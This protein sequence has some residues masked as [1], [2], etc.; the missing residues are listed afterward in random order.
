MKKTDKAYRKGI[1]WLLLRSLLI[2]PLII[3]VLGVFGLGWWWALVPALLLNSLYWYRYNQKYQITN[4]AAE[5]TALIISLIFYY[6]GISILLMAYHYNY[7]A[8]PNSFFGLLTFPYNLSSLI[9]G[10][11]LLY[12]RF[13]WFIIGTFWS[14]SL[15][16]VCYQIMTK[17]L[18]K[19]SE[20]RL[21]GLGILVVISCFPFYQ[22][23]SKSLQY[24]GTEGTSSELNLKPYRPFTRHADLARLKSPT[25]FQITTH[26]PRLDGAT[27]AYPIY[28]AVAQTLY[29]GLTAKPASKLIRVGTTPQAF[30]RLI[31]KQ[32]DVIFMAQPSA[33]QYQAAKRAHVHLKLTKIGSEAFVFFVNRRNP[34]NSLSIKQIRSIYQRKILFWSSVGGRFRTIQPFQRAK[35]SGSQTAMEKLIMGNH[36]MAKPLRYQSVDEMGEIVDDVASYNNHSNAIGYSFRFYMT[37]M[38]RNPKIKL[39]KINHI[40][41]TAANIRNGRYPLIAGIYAISRTGEPKNSQRLICWLKSR[42]GQKLIDQTGYVSL[43]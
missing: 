15:G 39:L 37:Q 14:G 25:A 6:G 30:H 5:I 33:S 2:S 41:P 21:I 19:F 10:G 43:R 8:I 31:H 40:A 9:A 1:W 17:Q 11:F 18:P 12:N 28:S 34:V 13:I 3:G 26:Y 20:K 4:M 24:V 22:Q 23:F 36:K 16:I 38:K 32:A 27:A 7:L 42:D 35:N 29:K